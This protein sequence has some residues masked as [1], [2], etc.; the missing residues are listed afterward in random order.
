MLIQSP[1]LVFKLEIALTSDFK[2]AQRSLLIFLLVLPVVPSPILIQI[3]TLVKTATGHRC[4]Q[5]L[6]ALELPSTLFGHKP[7]RAIEL[8]SIVRQAKIL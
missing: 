6:T 3:L 8:E 4:L 7:S 5:G 1:L 2:L